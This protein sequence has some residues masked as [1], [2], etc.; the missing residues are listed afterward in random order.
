MDL[1]WFCLVQYTSCKMLLDIHTLLSSNSDRRKH[2]WIRLYVLVIIFKCRMWNERGHVW[3]GLCDRWTNVQ[4]EDLKKYTEVTGSWH[5]SDLLL[6]FYAFYHV[7]SSPIWYSFVH[8]TRWSL[9]L[10][11]RSVL[12]HRAGQGHAQLTTRIMWTYS[13]RGISGGHRKLDIPR[14][15]INLERALATCC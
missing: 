11:L 5:Y 14:V 3:D 8:W 6:N 13:Q 2:K 10:F 15:E 9:R 7:W 12:V 4:E 1:T